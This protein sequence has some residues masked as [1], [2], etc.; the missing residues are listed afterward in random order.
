MHQAI[1]ATA[2]LFALALGG[3]AAAAPAASTDPVDPVPAHTPPAVPAALP[4]PA[5]PA[6]P[7]PL[8]VPHDFA[9]WIERAAQQCPGLSRELIAA[10]IQAESDFNPN[11]VSPAN[12]VGPSQFIPSSWEVWGVDADGD[13][14]R[15]PFSIPDA[16]TAQ[17]AFMCENLKQTTAGVASGR[18]DGDPVDLALAAYNAGYGAV[19]RFS[20]MPA[21]GGYTAETQPYVAKIRQLEQQL[22]ARA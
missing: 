6:T 8:P 21:G 3:A 18:L 19:L 14:A 15:N 5:A 22:A 2:S 4:V 13:G 1:T 20:G 10:Q 17:A 11:A 16:V 9:T 7:A 12:A